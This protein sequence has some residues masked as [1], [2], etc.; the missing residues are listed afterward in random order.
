[1]PNSAEGNAAT[2]VLSAHK[3]VKTQAPP[4]SFLLHLFPFYCIFL[5]S[6]P[7]LFF[8]LHL[9]P[10]YSI[11]PLPAPPPLTLPTRLYTTKLTWNASL[12]KRLDC[13]VSQSGPYRPP[14]GVEEMQGGGRRVRLE[15]RA[16]ITV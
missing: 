3:L 9:P 7:S 1:M 8:L 16:Y 13:S 10:S 11:F 5:L 2:S 15:W 4:P 12:F 14:G 6:N